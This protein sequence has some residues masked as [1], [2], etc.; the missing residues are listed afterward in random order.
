MDMQMAMHAQLMANL[1]TAPYAQLILQVTTR[2]PDT[3]DVQRQ[4]IA[5][6]SHGNQMSRICGT[7]DAQEMIYAV[8]EKLFASATV[9]GY[10][11]QDEATRLIIGM[12]SHAAAM[13]RIVS[14]GAAEIYGTVRPIVDDT[15]PTD[16]QQLDRLKLRLES[17][18]AEISNISHRMQMERLT[19]SIS[20]R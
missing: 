8:T 13:A 3:G 7:T 10:A 1:C 6:I 4:V 20:R 15:L 14:D 2:H 9:N 19:R 17:A 12:V 5:M 16:T 11:F 18:R